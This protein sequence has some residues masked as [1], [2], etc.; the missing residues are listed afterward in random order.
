MTLEM[1]DLRKAKKAPTRPPRRVDHRR[2]PEVGDEDAIDWRGQAT[3]A[4]RIEYEHYS[5]R[6]Y[7]D[8]Q[9][10]NN[11]E[12]AYKV[13][14]ENVMM[15][16]APSDP[17]KAKDEPT[18]VDKPNWLK[19]KLCPAKPATSASEETELQ[20]IEAKLLK[21]HEACADAP[22]AEPEGC[23]ERCAKKM[24]TLKTAAFL[25]WDG[26]GF[27][28]FAFY[29]L[30]RLRGNPPGWVTK[31]KDGVF[32][33]QNLLVAAALAYIIHGALLTVGEQS[34]DKLGSS[35]T[36]EISYIVGEN[37]QMVASVKFDEK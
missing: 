21:R 16:Y 30:D 15:A 4:K 3:T 33:V 35:P 29:K 26:I 27:F 22:P 17:N 25:L 24:K 36:K 13:A 2:K 12:E 20:A 8:Q 34:L 31:L 28:G 1:V 37:A 9:W 18:K 14:Q 6:F 10:F 7:E 11:Y 32:I 19:S 23:G 5:Q